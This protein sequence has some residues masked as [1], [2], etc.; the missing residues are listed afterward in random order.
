MYGRDVLRTTNKKENAW[1][2][3]VKIGIW[4]SLPIVVADTFARWSVER[5]RE[6]I[7]GSVLSLFREK[8]SE[9]ENR[10]LF[11]K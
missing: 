9:E 5:E 3:R 4:V 8:R 11:A 2:S 10:S 1:A 7:D 6:K